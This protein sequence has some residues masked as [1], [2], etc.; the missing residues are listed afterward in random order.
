MDDKKTQNTPETQP[1]T[2]PAPE[3]AEAVT[4]DTTLIGKPIEE[5]K[6]AELAALASQLSNLTTSITDRQKAIKDTVEK[7]AFGKI[8]EVAKEQAKILGWEKL[9]K[10][11]CMPDDAGENYNVNYVSTKRKS[12]GSKRAPADVNTGAITIN[13]IGIAMGGIAWFKDKDG[14]EHE[15]IKDLVKALK[16]PE[17]GDSESDRCWDIVKKGISASDI[18]IKYHADEVTLIFNDSTEKLVKV[19]VDEMEAARAAS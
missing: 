13:K 7:D 17:T 2:K 1:E 15:G 18:V 6:P 9:P 14:T 12:N 16:N 5:L 4:L 11:M 10:I 3:E 19:A 8:A